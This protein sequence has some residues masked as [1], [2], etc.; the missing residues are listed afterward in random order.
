MFAKFA[1]GT[2]FDPSLTK[3]NF[4]FDEQIHFNMNSLN[5][6]EGQIC[7]TLSTGRSPANTLNLDFSQFPDLDMSEI[8]I[9]SCLERQVQTTTPV[10]VGVWSYEILAW[11]RDPNENPRAPS[12]EKN[13]QPHPLRW[14]WQYKV[15]M[16]HPNMQSHL[17]VSS[18]PRT[19]QNHN[20][21]QHPITREHANKQRATHARSHRVNEGAT[22]PPQYKDNLILLLPKDIKETQ[23]K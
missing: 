13:R 4:D 7:L 5:P 9:W 18:N 8:K 21:T 2:L 23:L 15:Q 11:F 1:L 12:M 10:D 6:N 22:H 3:Y 20:E 17:A 19:H 14:V 16:S